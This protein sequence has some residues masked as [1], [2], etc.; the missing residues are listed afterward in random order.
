MNQDAS[1][2]ILALPIRQDDSPLYDHQPH[3]F[4]PKLPTPSPRIDDQHMFL[5][6]G[7]I[8]KET[9]ASPDLRGEASVSHPDRAIQATRTA[10]DHH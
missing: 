3:S 4:S 1:G 7:W 6:K 2:L 10:T 8:K 5:G 9:T